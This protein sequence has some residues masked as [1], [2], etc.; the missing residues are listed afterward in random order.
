[1]IV[2]WE[3]PPKESQNGIIVGYKIR[4][5]LKGSRRGDTVTTD[6][7]RRL[8]A[9]TGKNKELYGNNLIVW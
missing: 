2:R 7:N 6:G 9:I 5:K 8:F 3:P 4:F 1:M